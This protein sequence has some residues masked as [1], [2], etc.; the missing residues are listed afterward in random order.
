MGRRGKT[1]QGMVMVDKIKEFWHDQIPGWFPIFVAIIGAA[2]WIGQQQQNITDRL[3]NLEKQ[4]MAI[5]DYL[6]NEHGPKGLAVPPPISQLR[7]PQLEA[8]E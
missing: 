5:Q 1:R 3:S 6:R 8:H 2:F 4:V 7:T